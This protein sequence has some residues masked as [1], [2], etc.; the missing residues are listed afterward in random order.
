V[1]FTL[2]TDLSTMQ[3]QVDIDEAD[4]GSIREGQSASFTVDAYPQRQFQAKLISVRNAP[5]TTNGVV[6]YQGV[7]A[8]DN[9]SMLLRP[10]MT[11]NVNITVRKALMSFWSPMAPCA[12]PRRARSHPPL[13]MQQFGGPTIPAGC[14]CWKTENP[15]RVR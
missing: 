4:I 2:A 15:F 11:A 6:T 5:K 1:L 8:V 3:L 9:S 12:L 7:L 10:G 13:L 14:G